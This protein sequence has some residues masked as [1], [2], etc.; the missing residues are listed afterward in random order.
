MSGSQTPK[1]QK[2]QKPV[3]P[4]LGDEPNLTLN[5]M[6]ELLE[7]IDAG[8][9]VF[10]R[11]FKL[12]GWN[13]RFLE[14]SNYPKKFGKRYTLYTDFIR[15]N[16]EHNIYGPGDIEQ[17]ITDR[18]ERARQLKPYSYTRIQ[19]NHTVLRISFRPDANGGFVK[20]YTDITSEAQAQEVI[21]WNKTTLKILAEIGNDWFWETDTKHNFVTYKGYREVT[22][23]PIEGVTGVPRWKN[24]SN[25]DL[26]DTKKWE[27]HRAILDAHKEFRDFEFE[28]RAV[29]PEWIRV[30]GDPIFDETGKFTGHRGVATIITERKLAEIDANRK[31]SEEYA[32]GKLLH[33]SLE[34]SP[35]GT[36]LQ[37]CIEK[38]L[39]QVSWLNL[40]PSG[41]IFLANDGDTL[42]LS[43]HH[44]LAPQLVT[45][46]N[47]VPFGKCH[48]GQAAK[49]HSI[50][51][52]DC[53]DERHEITFDGIK[54]HGHYN[55]PI[56]HEE[57]LLG[58]IVLYLPHGHPKSTQDISFLT[59]V[60]NVLSMG[61]LA[62][63]NAQALSE[64][65]ELFSKAFASS[66]AA[67][68]ISGLEDGYIYNV[69]ARWLSM[70]GY[71]K[72]DVIGKY[73]PDLSLLRNSG[74]R[75]DILR[76]LKQR[77][78]IRDFETI[79]L[80]KS[81][82]ER[83]VILSAE[84]IEINSVKHILTVIQD[85]TERKR[86]KKQ[87]TQLISAI[88]AL[89]E[90]IT[91]YDSDDRL[92]FFNEQLRELYK[93]DP[94]AT[95]LGT[96]FEDR[97]RVNIANGF[98]PEAQGNAEQWLQRRMERHRNPSGAF[99]VRLRN[100]KYV[101][102]REQRLPDGGMIV[103]ATDITERKQL[104]R[105]VQRSQKMDAI[106]Q[107]TGG[108]AHD[109]NN[110]LGIVMGNLELLT[111]VIPSDDN[112]AN[113][114]K[115]ALKGVNRG[116]EITRKLLGFSG[117]NTQKSQI[118]PVNDFI[119]NIEDLIAKSLTTSI[120]VE[121]HLADDIWAVD[122]N[123]GDLEDTLLNLSLNARDAMPNGGTL[124]IET[125]NKTLNNDYLQSNPDDQSGDYVMISVSDTGI[126]MSDEVRD[127]VLEPFFTTKAHG[128]GTGLGL[129]MVYG[130]VQRS[131]GHL[132]IYSE[133]DKGTVIRLYLPR[134]K[135]PVDNTSPENPIRTQLPQGTETILVVDDEEALRAVASTRLKAF[136]YNILEAQNGVHALKIIKENKNIDLLFTDIVMPGT[137]DGYQLSLAA[138][139]TRPNLKVLV[140]SG[141]TKRQGNFFQKNKTILAHLHENL[142][143]KPYNK[144]ELAIAIRKTLDQS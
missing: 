60:A 108:I 70:L 139:K 66:P 132:K 20:T 7:N 52:S 53:V 51:Y 29:P 69:N 31:A 18:V 45:L 85:I 81:G 94:N 88:N 91:I 102:V 112:A 77:H 100:G 12:I 116:T 27:E 121:T 39:S 42:K 101:L 41:G 93:D 33:L 110:I 130:F 120:K 89:S 23:L 136:G 141:F 46:C 76:Q 119:S 137:M 92:V 1:N 131:G 25:R 49:T 9:S 2:N 73:A 30:S 124:V 96:R 5:I 106:G 24:A 117:R 109:F 87:T 14:I 107:L 10:D 71:S 67:I 72:D 64:T 35:L 144:A 129:S 82:E 123:P 83:N 113:Y 13:K 37:A 95:I 16:A 74:D 61:I 11:E 19:P 68:G 103:L 133:I 58:V 79:Y 105:Q 114:V 99:E 50:Q 140:T 57:A 8:I 97:L 128:K 126:G 34:L 32:L 135:G 47:L 48:C 4:N 22:G 84:L 138:L 3:Q 15:Y 36:Y 86:A 122:I 78:F 134:A 55:V 44:N 63:K 17:L 6:Q 111:E 118:T 28:V 54:Q 43:A 90:N 59:R 21:D 104:E 98:L 125:V 62:R 127:K 75:D 38:L 142:L 65:E 56:L 80:T 143:N 26:L 115:N 40:L